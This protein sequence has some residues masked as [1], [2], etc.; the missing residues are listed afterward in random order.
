MKVGNLVII[1]ATV[2]ISGCET[3]YHHNTVY[4]L[5]TLESDTSDFEFLQIDTGLSSKFKP[6]YC[7]TNHYKG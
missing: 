4:Q 1:I 7:T 5:D 6:N 3:V 2:A